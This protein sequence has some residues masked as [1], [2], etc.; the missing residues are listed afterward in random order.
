[1]GAGSA[2]RGSLRASGAWPLA[3]PL[4]SG[5]LGRQRLRRSRVGPEDRFCEARMRS[6]VE[7]GGADPDNARRSGS[8]PRDLRPAI[9]AADAT[10]DGTILS[11]DC[12]AHT[13]YLPIPLLTV[14]MA[15]T[16][17]Q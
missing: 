14:E 2:G 13:G 4:P 9:G 12:V 5:P 8:G 7:A 10:P 11:V 15:R 3:W 6:T 16:D 1:M 17:A